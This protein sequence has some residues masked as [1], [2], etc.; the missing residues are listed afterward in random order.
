MSDPGK[1]TF[2]FFKVLMSD[3]KF[4]EK[5]VKLLVLFR[6]HFR[7]IFMLQFSFSLTRR[8]PIYTVTKT[9]KMLFYLATFSSRPISNPTEKR[10][11]RKINCE[12]F[13]VS[14]LVSFAVFG[15]F[16]LAQIIRF[17]TQK[18]FLLSFYCLENFAKIKVGTRNC[19]KNFPFQKC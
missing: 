10:Q 11:R 16:S 17:F 5:R 7:L 2:K 8:S 14:L 6:V 19:R 1:K 3:E 18:F 9:R 13:L 4:H 12:S 15:I